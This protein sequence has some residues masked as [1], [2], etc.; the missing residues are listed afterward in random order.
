MIKMD[1]QLLEHRRINRIEKLRKSDG[2]MAGMK[3]GHE[4]CRFDVQRGEQVRRAVPFVIMRAPLDLARS[5]GQQWLR[6]VEGLNLLFL[7]D[8][9]HDGV[10]GRIHVQPDDVAYLFDQ[11]RIGERRPKHCRRAVH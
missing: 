2:A 11:E 10:R 3:F 1:V 6:P 9:E 8:T 7:I 5:H 4:L